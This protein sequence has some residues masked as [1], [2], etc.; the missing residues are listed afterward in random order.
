[1][2]SIGR[3]CLKDS[4]NSDAGYSIF[5]CDNGFLYE[6]VSYR[7]GVS[8]ESFEIFKSNDSFDALKIQ[9]EHKKAT[10]TATKTSR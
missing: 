4:S 1:M 2:W 7:N 6:L 5:S 9:F 8:V 10:S 3:S